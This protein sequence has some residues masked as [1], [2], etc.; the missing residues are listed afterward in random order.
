[1]IRGTS[2]FVFL[3]CLISCTNRSYIPD[4]IIR[5]AQMEDILWDMIRADL[6]AHEIIKKDSTK[7]LNN[8]TNILTGKVL[9]IHHIDKVKFDRS[10]R[11]YEKHPD[12]MNLIL[13]SLNAKKNRDKI[14]EMREISEKNK[15]KESQ[16]KVVPKR[17]F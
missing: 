17:F 4:N 12:I 3:F 14:A 16:K 2:I 11:F 6:L 13:D 9:A 15:I 1:M 10:I 5:K 8:E 7:N